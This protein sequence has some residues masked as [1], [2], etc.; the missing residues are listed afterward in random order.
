MSVFPQQVQK[1]RVEHRR[2]SSPSTW[3]NLTTVSDLHN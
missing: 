1:Q 3:W 2:A